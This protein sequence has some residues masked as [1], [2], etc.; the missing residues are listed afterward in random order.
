MEKIRERPN[1]LREVPQDGSEII[2]QSIANKNEEQ[3]SKSIQNRNMLEFINTNTNKIKETIVQNNKQDQFVEYVQKIAENHTRE[4]E[5]MDTQHRALFEKVEENRV[6]LETIE[7]GIKVNKENQIRTI[8]SQ[9]VIINPQ[10]KNEKR[11]EEFKNILESINEKQTKFEEGNNKE[12]QKRQ[13]NHKETKA[14]IINVF[15]RYEEEREKRSEDRWKNEREQD[16]MKEMLEAI[17]EEQLNLE[18]KLMDGVQTRQEN[19]EETK[20]LIISSSKRPR[21]E[22]K[23]EKP[24]EA[25]IPQMIGKGN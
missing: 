11:Q 8:N 13:E 2:C 12:T 1:R 3:Q 4:T 17:K 15:K 21:K 22:E 14:L 9:E 23:G 6:K 10:N 5:T 24:E 19:H 7:E 20:T 18:K 16:E 25:I